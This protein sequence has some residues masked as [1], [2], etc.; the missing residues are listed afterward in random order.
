MIDA[1]I[2]LETDINQH[3]SRMAGNH[4]MERPIP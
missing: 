4:A 1:F 2:R 3:D